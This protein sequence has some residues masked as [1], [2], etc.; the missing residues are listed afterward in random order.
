M[1]PSLIVTVVAGAAIKRGQ[2]VT[3][4]DDGKAYPILPYTSLPVTVAT[5]DIAKDERI[6]LSIDGNTDLVEE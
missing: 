4:E 3:I 6:T 5:R 1:L 2:A